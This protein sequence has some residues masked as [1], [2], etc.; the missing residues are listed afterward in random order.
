MLN[1]AFCVVNNGVG[2][3]MA[4][5]VRTGDWMSSPWAEHYVHAI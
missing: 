4:V 2:F 1:F 3:F 5:N